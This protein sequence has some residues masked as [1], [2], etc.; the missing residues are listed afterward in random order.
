MLYMIKILGYNC[1]K[2]NITSKYII[3]FTPL[4]KNYVF[5]IPTNPIFEVDFI[6]NIGKDFKIF[7][8]FLKKIIKDKEYCDNTIDQVKNLHKWLNCN[9]ES[10]IN[11]TATNI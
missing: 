8:I 9:I 2:K 3:N 5:V 4:N 6:N 10:M 1:D 7:F 11:N